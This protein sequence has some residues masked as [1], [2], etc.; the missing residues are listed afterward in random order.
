MRA[1]WRAAFSLNNV[2]MRNKMLIVYFLSVFIPVVLTNVIF[3]N[4]T[5]NNVK[6]QKMR[7]ISLA[8]EQIRNDFMAQVNAAVGI[9]AVIY[10][11]TILNQYLEE[12]YEV[13]SDYVNNY[14]SYIIG[15]LSKYSPVYEAI[16]RITLYSNNSTII[17]GGQ[18]EPITKQ[19]RE[20][21]W[22]RRISASELSTPILLKTSTDYPG[23]SGEALSIVRKISNSGGSEQ[24]EKILKIDLHP[25][26]IKELFHNVT[27][28]GNLYLLRGNEVQ[29]TTNP[30]ISPARLADF[31]SFPASKGTLVFD[32]DFP[33]VSYLSKWRIVGEFRESAVLE[34]VHKSRIS[35]LYLAVPNLLLSTLVIIWFTRSL[36][37]RL[38]RILKHMKRVKNHSF[39][40]ISYQDNKDEIGQL[41]AEFNRMTL[42]IKSLIHDVYIADIQKKELQ[43]KR[44]QSQLHALQSQ[45]NPHF[46]FNSLETIRMRSLMKKEEETAK[47]IH[48]MAKIFRKSLAWGKDWV[49]IRD[50]LDLVA[51]F[52]EIQKYRFGDKLDFRIEADDSVMDMMIPKM[53][54]QPLVENASIHGIEKSKE[55]GLIRVAVGTTEEGLVCTVKDNGAGI[56]AAKL[57]AILSE[58]ELSEDIG[59]SVGIK[60]VYYRLKMYYQER[61][62]FEATSEEGKGTE[63]RIVVKDEPNG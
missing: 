58:L 32:E 23:A 50:E 29:Y 62:R 25:E 45:I 49:T 1:N 51:C 37:A 26:A 3:Y 2:R 20:Q 4:I 9:S 14:Q 53:T 34:E 57:E 12:S 8:I 13:P 18:V 11:D 59:E 21:I 28:E 7:D 22:Y 61:V 56:P 15:M 41:T 16:Q 31:S 5:S 33:D 39:D 36:N 54:L 24:W 27:L 40:T 10:N 30:A 35:V 48:N 52:L 17:Y 63:F 6:K 38:V 19:T 60:N 55:G 44:N 47:I 43:L 46:L 42:Q